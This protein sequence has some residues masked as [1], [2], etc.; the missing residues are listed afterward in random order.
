MTKTPRNPLLPSLALL[1][2]VLA[3]ALVGYG[4]YKK[5]SQAT[6]P[7]LN[8]AQKSILQDD[9]I[10]PTTQESQAPS[11][12][13][14]KGKVYKTSAASVGNLRLFTD[15]TFDSISTNMGLSS[16][17]DD[18]A[19]FIKP[20]DLVRLFDSSG[21]KLGFIGEVTSIGKGLMEQS[22]K[23]TIITTLFLT[24]NPD[25]LAKIHSAQIIN[26]NEETSIPR[27]PK[28]AIVKDSAGV[29]FV[30]EIVQG[31]G[32]VSVRKKPANITVESDEYVAIT[33][34]FGGSN[35]YI[36]NPDDKLQ[37]LAIITVA[38][39]PY[40]PKPE[41]EEKTIARKY[42][43]AMGESAQVSVENY[44]HTR[45]GGQTADPNAPTPKGQSSSCGSPE[46][47]FVCEKEKPPM[48]GVMQLPMP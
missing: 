4:F 39:I 44:I 43:S 42:Y 34:E 38:N 7:P 8:V 13:V 32:P 48:Q 9:G 37:D 36:L 47:S 5:N 22:A 26:Y 11:P 35:I 28:E 18:D 30:W 12:V 15:I 17:P 1:V 14:I 46:A 21:K 20:G 2:V 33:P 16:I 40:A 45:P 3:G 27:L 24:Q 10:Q 25:D 41:T 6:Q 31:Q 19:T 23:L 29:R